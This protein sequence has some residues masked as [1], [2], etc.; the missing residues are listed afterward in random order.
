MMHRMEAEKHGQSERYLEMRQMCQLER[1]STGY[2]LICHSLVLLDQPRLS[3]QGK[4]TGPGGSAPAC[5]SSFPG[6][7]GTGFGGKSEPWEKRSTAASS[8]W[9]TSIPLPHEP[10]TIPPKTSQSLRPGQFD[11]DFLPDSAA[12]SAC[13]LLPGS[14]FYPTMHYDPTPSI[15]HY[16]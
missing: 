7:V 13:C 3:G 16:L 11:S 14:L 4:D 12:V 2:P 10:L 1:P 15:K 5:P 8:V 9:L 6:L